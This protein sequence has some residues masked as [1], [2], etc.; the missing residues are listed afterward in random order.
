[1]TIYRYSVY[2][3]DPQGE[4]I[5]SGRFASLAAAQAAAELLEEVGI[6]YIIVPTTTLSPVVGTVED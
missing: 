5:A 2:A 4:H 1:M 3:I 6:D